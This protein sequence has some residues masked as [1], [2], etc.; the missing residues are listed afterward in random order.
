MLVLGL[1]MEL[2][3]VAPLVE[4]PALILGDCLHTAD[5]EGEM[6]EAVMVVPGQWTVIELSIAA[7]AVMLHAD[8]AEVD[9]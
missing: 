6:G 3:A 9:Q 2:S 8:I 1:S 4:R 5:A 7:A